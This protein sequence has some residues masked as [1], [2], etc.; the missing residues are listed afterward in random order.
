MRRPGAVRVLVLGGGPAGTT[1]A[2][3]ARELGAEVTLVE[4]K[5]LGGTSLNEGP[6]P[7]RTLAR[8]ARLVRDAGSWGQ[9]GLRGDPP[10]V[11]LAAA[12][13]NAGRLAVYAHEERR[14]V[15]LV[16][17]YGIDVVQ[18]AGPAVFVDPH[19][20]RVPDGRVL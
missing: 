3:Q 12:L 18:D 19:T 9:F 4:A 5:R 8:A 1:A 15:D 6:G 13:H 11:D 7:V 14:L 10:L 17:D 16:R 2:L 20:V